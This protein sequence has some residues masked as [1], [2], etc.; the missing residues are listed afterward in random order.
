MQKKFCRRL[1]SLA[2]TGMAFLAQSQNP[3]KIGDALP[4]QFW[5]T[6]LQMVNTPQKTTTLSADKD[7]LIL[8]DFWNTWCSACILNFPKME[9]LQKQFGDKIKILAVSNQDRATLEKFFASKN[10]SKY[11]QVQSVAGDKLMTKLFPHVAVPYIVWVKDGKVLSTTDAGQVNAHTLSEILKDQKSVLQTVVQ[12]EKDNGP[13]LLDKNLGNETLFEPGH[14]VLFG[15]GRIRGLGYGSGF[16]N[17]GKVTYGRM[18]TNLSLYEIY[19]SITD[20]IYSANKQIFSKNRI[21]V[22]VKNPADFYTKAENAP[23]GQENNIYTYDFIVPLAMAD[24]LYPMMLAELNT[25]SAYTATFEKRKMPCFALIRTGGIDRLASKGGTP[26]FMMTPAEAVIRNG[27][28]YTLVNNL[29]GFE[30]FGKPV[31]DDT[32]YNGAIDLVLKDLSTI[33]KV[34]AALKPYGLDLLETEREMDV[35]VV[36]DK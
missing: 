20:E 8:L 6:P 18:Y 35:L 17:K 36:R 7:K 10:G 11:N 13:L 5:E 22:E 26:Q 15:K 16:H 25:Y 29:N 4:K 31:T 32:G 33:D 9:E 21:V 1:L 28:I 27:S 34:R 24:R 2:L 23:V 14:Y 19:Y 12:F 30:M 3:L